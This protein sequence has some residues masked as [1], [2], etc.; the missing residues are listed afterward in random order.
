MSI[1]KKLEMQEYIHLTDEDIYHIKKSNHPDTPEYL[2]YESHKFY[3]CS[4]PFKEKNALL[5]L[6]KPIPDDQTF[7]EINGVISDLRMG[8]FWNTAYRGVSK[9]TKIICNLRSK[10]RSLF[11]KQSIRVQPGRETPHVINQALYRKYSEDSDILIPG[12]VID[13]IIHENGKFVSSIAPIPL[14]DRNELTSELRTFDYLGP[15]SFLE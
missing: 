8:T 5:V 4:I 6:Q 10:A 2:R 11:D 14:E 9:K 7:E 3:E 13:T 15:I 12:Y 1:D